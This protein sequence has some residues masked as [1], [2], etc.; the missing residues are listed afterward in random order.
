MRILSV[1][2]IAFTVL[3]IAGCSPGAPDPEGSERTTVPSRAEVEASG[4]CSEDADCICG[5]VDTFTGD[6]F[7]GN[8]DYYDKYVDDSQVCPDFCTGIAGNLVSRCVNSECMQTYECLKSSDCS[9]GKHCRNNQCVS[10]LKRAEC[11]VDSDCKRD[12]CSG[13]LCVASV[14]DDTGMVTTCEFLPEYECLSLVDCGCDDGSCCWSSS[15]DYTRCVEDA[16]E[17]MLPPP[18]LR[19]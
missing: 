4:S 15:P 16:R 19:E 17:S 5:G 14:K 12:G 1:F 8:K 6:C 18:G 10:S 11:L 3:L 13:Q 2:I 9:F 7:L